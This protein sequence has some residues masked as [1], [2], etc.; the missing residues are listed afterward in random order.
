MSGNEWWRN[1]TCP[2]CNYVGVDCK[3]AT[4]NDD[5]K[6]KHSKPI[7]IPHK[8]KKGIK[9]IKYKVCNKC[10]KLIYFCKC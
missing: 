4:H 2:N 1:S 7:L 5:E 9:S 6:P 3:C 8:D 10:N